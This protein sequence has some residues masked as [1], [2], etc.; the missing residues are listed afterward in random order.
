MGHGTQRYLVERAAGGGSYRPVPAVPPEGIESEKEFVMKDEGV[1]Q[2]EDWS[3]PE[4]I[5]TSAVPVM[6]VGLAAEEQGE[7]QE[8]LLRRFRPSPEVMMV[9]SSDN[10][11]EN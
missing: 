2:W 11:L 1:T 7:H 5:Q 10:A 8:E 4:H 9:S 3:D 6:S